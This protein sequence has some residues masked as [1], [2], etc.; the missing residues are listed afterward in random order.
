MEW[1]G[2]TL[3][4]ISAFSLDGMRLEGRVVDVYDGDTMTLILDPWGVSAWKFQV[5]IAGI[6]TCEIRSKEEALVE[7][8][9]HTRAKVVE[10]V[11]GGKFV[12]VA[13]KKEVRQ[14]LNGDDVFMVDIECGKFDKYGRLLGQVTT[15]DGKDVAGELLA[16][17]LAKTYDGGKKEDW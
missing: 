2:K 9:K 1:S 10:L 14:A 4:T 8:A 7:K 16:L 11:T 12:G 3:D 5:R 17:G 15:C 13:E 6:D